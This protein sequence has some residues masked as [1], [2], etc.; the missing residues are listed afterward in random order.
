MLSSK[1]LS[2]REKLLHKR[3]EQCIALWQAQDPHPRCELFYITPYQ[4]LI[5]VV[6]SAQATDKSVNAAMRNLYEQGFGPQEV[7]R[8]G[9]GGFHTIIKTI[10]LANAKAKN[11][12]AL[13]KLLAAQG[14]RIPD[15]REELIKL[16]GVGIKTASVVLGE[17]YGQPTLAVDTHVF[18]VGARLGLHHEK[19]PEKAAA[20]LLRVI[21][22]KHLPKAHHWMV[23][24]GRYICTAK[25]PKCGVCVLREL[26]PSRGEF[27]GK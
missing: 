16:P 8:L 15:T 11:V 12:V 27:E 25:K 7:L 20:A 2:S 14:F 19:T 17:L 13:T 23:M 22:A 24:H 3:A 1:S 26:C 10:G 18:R 6:L 21:D 9:E 4:L 5:S